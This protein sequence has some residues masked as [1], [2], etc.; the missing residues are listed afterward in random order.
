MLLRDVLACHI[1]LS[2][3]GLSSAAWSASHLLH[4]GMRYHLE[5]IYSELLRNTSS[6]GSDGVQSE[7]L[8]EKSP[9]SLNE[10]SCVARLFQGKRS[11]PYNAI[12]C[13]LTYQNGKMAAVRLDLSRDVVTLDSHM[14]VDKR[15]SM[16]FRGPGARILTDALIHLAKENS[17]VQSTGQR[18]RLQRLRAMEPELSCEKDVSVGDCLL[19]L[20]PASAKR[21]SID[22]GHNAVLFYYGVFHGMQGSM[23]DSIQLHEIA[24]ASCHFNGLYPEGGHPGIYDD[25]A[26]LSCEYT[27]HNGE[28]GMETR[29]LKESISHAW[30]NRFGPKAVAITGVDAERLYLALEHMRMDPANLVNPEPALNKSNLNMGNF[31]FYSEVSL[32]RFQPSPLQG[33]KGVSVFCHYSTYQ[34]K[35]S[36]MFSSLIQSPGTAQTCVFISP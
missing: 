24:S 35:H 25:D 19:E 32:R 27:L 15:G 34:N 8:S 11:A 1:F 14:S 20:P 4:I 3:F 5:P 2:F 30:G 33:D 6:T 18:W 29:M 28:S 17:R 7:G 23:R 36:S 12:E 13:S 9:L 16:R 21:I 31:Y 22:L 26:S 10:T